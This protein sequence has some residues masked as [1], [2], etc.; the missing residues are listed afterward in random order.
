MLAAL[1]VIM[2]LF[3]EPLHAAATAPSPAIRMNVHDL[4][5]ISSLLEMAAHAKMARAASALND[6]TSGGHPAEVV[7]CE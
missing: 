7:T 4:L 3:A 2:L 5:M 1:L 6:V